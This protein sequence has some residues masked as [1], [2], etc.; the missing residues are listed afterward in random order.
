MAKLK[1][2]TGQKFGRLVVVC[3][4]YGYSRR[5]N[6]QWECKCD[7]GIVSVVDSG[8]L[9]SGRTVSCGNHPF[10]RRHKL[11]QGRRQVTPTYRTWAQMLARCRNPNNQDFARYG[12]RGITVCDAWRTFASFFEDMGE[13]PAG[14]SIDRIDNDSGYYKENC[15]WASSM[16]QANNRVSNHVIT[17]FGRALSISEWERESGISQYVIAQRVNK[18]GWS[19]ENSVSRPTRPCKRKER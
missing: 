13:K 8:N 19:A 3:R 12:G 18:L 17:A 16:T 6:A 7:C 4:V 1:D 5:H 10:K 14:M 15:R 11:P 9:R 2:I